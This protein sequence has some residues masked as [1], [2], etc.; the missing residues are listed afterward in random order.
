[1]THELCTASTF[2]YA[3]LNPEDTEIAKMRLHVQFHVFVLLHVFYFRVFY[4]LLKYLTCIPVHDSF[5]S[6][7]LITSRRY[8][9]C[10][11]G[12]TQAQGPNKEGCPEYVPLVP[13]VS[14]YCTFRA[15]WYKR[16]L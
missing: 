8:G 5:L 12:V 1:M 2:I 11:D 4:F 7:A 13:A 6:C 15:I 3:T 16:Y 9:C 10:Q 14:I